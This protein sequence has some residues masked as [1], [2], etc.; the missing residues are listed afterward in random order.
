[1]FSAF[2]FRAICQKLVRFKRTYCNSKEDSALRHDNEKNVYV[3]LGT[4]VVALNLWQFCIC[5]E[6]KNA[7]PESMDLKTSNKIWN[8]LYVST[9]HGPLL[10][11]LITSKITTFHI[12]IGFG[13]IGC[14]IQF[15]LLCRSYQL[16]KPV[17]SFD[18]TRKKGRHFLLTKEVTVMNPETKET[19]KAVLFFDSGAD[20]T[21]ISDS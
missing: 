5:L 14:I 17:T 3:V 19:A 12:N 7:K 4:S 1:M 11:K 13:I 2:R 20:Q 16:L 6:S 21:Y 8:A 9:L 15:A 10:W 18:E